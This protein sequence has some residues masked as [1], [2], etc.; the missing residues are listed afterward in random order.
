MNRTHPWQRL[1]WKDWQHL[2]L[3]L[4]II[5]IITVTA[6]IG[7]VQMAS[8][9]DR[10]MQ[11][12][13]EDIRSSALGLVLLTSLAVAIW[14]VS[15]EQVKTP[16]A[17][18]LPISPAQ[19]WVALYLYPLLF[20]VIG[21]LIVTYFYGWANT[22]SIH[23]ALGV[24][25]GVTLFTVATSLTITLTAFAAI[26]FGAVW[27]FFHFIL[28][29]APEYWPYYPVAVAGALL[30]HLCWSAFQRNRRRPLGR[31]MA[32]VGMVVPF[33]IALAVNYVVTPPTS[34]A[35]ESGQSQRSQYP[36]QRIFGAYYNEGVSVQ[37]A[38]QNDQYSFLRKQYPEQARNGDY[39][40]AQ[41]KEAAKHAR[42][43]TLTF[44]EWPMGK[45]R[46]LQ[47]KKLTMVLSYRK[48]QREVIML[49][50][51]GPRAA[52]DVVA[53]QVDGTTTRRIMRLPANWLATH[54]SVRNIDAGVYEQR[55][56]SQS[57]DDRY[58]CLLMPSLYAV[59]MS[60]DLWLLDLEE[61]KARILLPQ[62][63]NRF[64]NHVSNIAWDKNRI[65]IVTSRNQA[66]EVQLP[67]G[68]MTRMAFG[69]EVAR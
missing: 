11:R 46:T 25:Y 13:A 58:L 45:E 44:N 31:V 1:W 26:V 5:A 24:M 27:V 30:G 21:G 33:G 16:L 47:L 49:Q 51:A 17:A 2:G 38:Y 19:R 54:L 61:G 6:A 52:M 23:I 20:S 29:D 57:P 43:N 48:A 9:H 32:V 41:H 15:S 34:S 18:L 22:G 60:Q 66:Y 68:K 69:Q 8:S 3:F 65:G 14:R 67:D 55:F 28:L 4:G 40:D 50:Q 39:S 42:R 63:S 64:E 59:P 56:V 35:M 53:W 7:A 62:L 10:N 12:F 36:Q 37:D